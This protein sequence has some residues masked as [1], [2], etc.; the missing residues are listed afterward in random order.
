MLVV[1]FC[2]PSKTLL[3][4]EF[5]NLKGVE[6][7]CPIVNSKRR[8]PR[9]NRQELRDQP[10]ISGLLFV[11]LEGLEGAEA[12]AKKDPS[13]GIRRMI[14]FGRPATITRTQLT[15]LFESAERA[16]G[17]VLESEQAP[18]FY[19]GDRVTIKGPLETIEF[20]VCSINQNKNRAGLESFVG[21][22]KCDADFSA[23]L[24]LKNQ[25]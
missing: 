9:R 10:L 21:N 23:L 4:N 24:L 2:R 20:L 7:Y 25:A 14:A 18:K 15:E 1:C 13:L 5:L 3:A 12:L 6:S 22:I 17:S 16:S 11:A 8:V 19:V